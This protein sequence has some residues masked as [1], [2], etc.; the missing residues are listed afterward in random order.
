MLLETCSIDEV[1][2]VPTYRHFFGK[3]LIGFSERVELCERMITPLGA[4]A[5]IT[6]IERTLP[7]SQGRML[8]TLTALIEEFPA[9]E[10]RL[11]IGADI[12]LETDRWHAWDEVVA[13]AP[14]IVFKR[15]GYE[16]GSLPAPPNVSSTDI[17]ERLGRGESAVP[18]IP[19]S[20]QKRISEL[21]LYR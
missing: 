15:H 7:N 8:D 6:E 9:H 14:P 1:W 20:V 11:V 4:R 5:R 17:R 19:S 3:A 10:F 12:L 16:G 18:L 13:L 21:G 2:L